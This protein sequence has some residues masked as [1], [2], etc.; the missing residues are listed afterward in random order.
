MTIVAQLAIGVSLMARPD[1]LAFAARTADC[2][3]LLGALVVTVAAVASAEVTRIARFVNVLFGLLLI[4]VA[5][6]FARDLPIAF[7]SEFISGI[8]LIV[9]S[10]PKGR[11]VERYAGW[12]KY[13]R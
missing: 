5:F 6:L 9:V 13:V 11:I 1:I 7:G 10:L 2:D 8:I 12:D 4:V 3:H